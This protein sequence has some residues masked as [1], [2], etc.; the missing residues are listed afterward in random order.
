MNAALIILL[1]SDLAYEWTKTLRQSDKGGQR[2]PAS[3][4]E[5][6]QK[7][8]PSRSHSGANSYF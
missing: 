3:G 1:L 4:M 5:F 8:L 6:Q 2:T 7:L